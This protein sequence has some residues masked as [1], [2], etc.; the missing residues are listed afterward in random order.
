MEKMA[1]SVAEAAE[2]LGL[3]QITIYRMLY[4]GKLRATKF[5]RVWRIK[6]EDLEAL[7]EE[8]EEVAEAQR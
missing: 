6:R 3:S 8:T 5:G 7:L 2:L 1:Y 4:S